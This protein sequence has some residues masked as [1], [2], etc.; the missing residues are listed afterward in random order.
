MPQGPRGKA[1]K[2]GDEADMRLLD[3]VRTK[4][5]MGGRPVKT[6]TIPGLLDKGRLDEAA[7]GGLGTKVKKEMATAKGPHLKGW[8]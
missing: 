5:H 8:T 3:S 6:L 1:S 4:G 2:K 7:I